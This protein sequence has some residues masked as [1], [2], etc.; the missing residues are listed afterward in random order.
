MLHDNE[1]HLCCMSIVITGEAASLVWY[2]QVSLP[3]RSHACQEEPENLQTVGVQWHWH[4]VWPTSVRLS[5]VSGRVQILKYG[6]LRGLSRDVVKT[7]CSLSIINWICRTSKHSH[8]FTLRADF[9]LLLFFDLRA[10]AI[11]TSQCPTVPLHTH[12]IDELITW[13]WTR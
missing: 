12:L 13:P 6:I 1:T 11:W 3:Q 7:F 4:N 2:P 10:G 9:L 8:I 5:S